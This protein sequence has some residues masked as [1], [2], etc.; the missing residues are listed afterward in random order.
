VFFNEGN[1][2]VGGEVELDI[3]FHSGWSA[4]R[5]L[6]ADIQLAFFL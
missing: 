4:C 1:G 5:Q 6:T 3:L 2:F